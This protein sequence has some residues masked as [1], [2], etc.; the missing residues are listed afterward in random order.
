MLIKQIGH[1]KINIVFL[2]KYLLKQSNLCVHAFQPNQI[3]PDM[4]NHHYQ[5]NNHDHQLRQY[6]QIWQLEEIEEIVLVE[7][8]IKLK[9]EQ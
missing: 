6:L 2:V 7:L 9:K 3:H 1:I 5:L 8:D 4:T